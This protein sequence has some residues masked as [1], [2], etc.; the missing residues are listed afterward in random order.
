MSRTDRNKGGCTVYLL[1]HG[2][3]RPDTVRRFVGR[4]DHPLNEKGQAQAL[5]W[6]QEL[7]R[8]PFSHIYCSN[9]VRSVE[10][11]RIIGCRIKA[12]LTS[13]PDLGEIDLGRWDGMPV[14]EVRRQFPQEY[15]WRGADLAGYRPPGGESFAD[16][17]L[18]VLPA[19]EAVGLQSEG[20]VLIV[21]HAGVNRVVLCHLLGM[22][23]DNLFR[24]EQEYGC[25]NI[26]EQATGSRVV[27]RMNMPAGGCCTT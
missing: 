16:L 2:D 22:P 5:W 12:P 17:S 3:S 10:T 9:L 1:R 27:R 6:R 15:E 11:A 24:L 26:L 23:L 25:L 18:R 20:N 13:L 4:T 14:S 19:F 7:S 21:G 8:I